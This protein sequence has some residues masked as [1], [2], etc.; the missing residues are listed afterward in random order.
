[1]PRAKKRPLP[2]RGVLS[3][4]EHRIEIKL[5]RVHTSGPYVCSCQLRDD[6]MIRTLA[7]AML[8][9]ML[10]KLGTVPSTVTFANPVPTPAQP[11]SAPV[12][13]SAPAHGRTL[14]D[15]PPFEE[16]TPTMSR[17]AHEGMIRDAQERRAR[18]ESISVLRRPPVTEEG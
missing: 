12:P 2:E 4:D 6:E 3:W 9:E 10:A 11:P 17:E 15:D 5:C 18:R 16:G 14:D 1:M 7:Q 13:V 8:Q